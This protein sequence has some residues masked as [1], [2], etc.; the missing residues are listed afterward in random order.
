MVEN[1][2]QHYIPRFYLKNFSVGGTYKAIGVFHLITS[3]YIPRGKLRTQAY[4]NYFYGKGSEPEQTLSILEG[5]SAAIIADIIQHKSLPPMLSQ[6]HHN[7]LLFTILQNSRTPYTAEELNEMADKSIK[8]VFSKDLKI[9]NHLDKVKISFRDPMK[10]ALRTAVLTSPITM[11]LKYKLLDNKTKSPFITSDNPVVYYNQFMETRKPL[12]ATTGLAC[13]GLKIF[14][15][16]SPKCSIVFYDRDTYKVG[17]KR[18][19]LVNI[20]NMQDICMLNMLQCISANESIYFNDQLTERDVR[21]LVEKTKKY[22]RKTKMNVSEYPG[23]K[24]NQGMSSLLHFYKSEIK[25][26]LSLSFIKI[27]KKAKAYRLGDR[28]VH[29]RDENVYR[30]HQEFLGFVHRGHYKLTDFDQFVKDSSMMKSNTQ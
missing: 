8:K 12:G 3:K 2:R 22:R 7:L 24:S 27:L 28:V 26:G 1:K 15:P 19:I 14:F 30:L 6:E 17:N 18:D 16:I 21:K 10:M 25:C 9:R 11:D 23:Q 20:T 5:H 13:K 29:V 4:K